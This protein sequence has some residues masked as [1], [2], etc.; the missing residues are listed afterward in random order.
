LIASKNSLI[1]RESTLNMEL[2]NHHF[3]KRQRSIPLLAELQ[4]CHTPQLFFIYLF[5]YL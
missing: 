1:G 5:I 3:D 2:R 4:W